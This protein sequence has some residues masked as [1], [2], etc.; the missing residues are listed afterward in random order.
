MSFST[1]K[2]IALLAV[3]AGVNKSRTPLS[4]LLILGFLG[5]AF[6]AI[7]FMLDLHVISRLP[8]DWG[9]FGVLLGAMMFPLGLILTVLA[10]A[11]L[12]TG[13]M[14][15]MT[16]AALSKK[17]SWA[18]LVRNWLWV[19]I[20]NFL[21]SVAVAWF[22][23]H[24]LGMTEGAFL[25]STLAVAAAK[26]SASGVQAFI[27]GIGCNWLVCLAIWLG[28]ASKDVTGK[29]IGIWFPVMAFVAIGFQHVVANM[30]IIP[31]AI[32]AGQGSWLA[33]LSN[34]IAVF[35]G[36]AVGGAIFVAL[37]Y[38]IAYRPD[39]QINSNRA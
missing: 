29:I 6:I 19:T 4:S 11:E 12:L 21:G 28:M 30:F 9:S 25:K 1:P 26:T 7:G 15:V 17:I 24:L 5:G 38:Y 13:N 14:M 32:F 20:G 37:I 27:S 36:N 18:A 16:I 3:Q 34:F 2:E 23:G 39:T 35:S 31:A 10:G 33:Y 8:A 22:F